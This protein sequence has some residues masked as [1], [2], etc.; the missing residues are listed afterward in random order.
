[1]TSLHTLSNTHRGRKSCKR[2]GRGIGSGLG[3]TCARGQKGAGARSGYKRRLGNEGGQKPLYR[4]LPGR[5]FSNARFQKRFDAV[6]IER[7]N[8]FFE[9][10]EV[11]SME[12]LYEKGLIGSKTYGVKVLSQ[13]DLT[14]KLSFQVHAMSAKSLEKLQAAQS[15]IELL[16]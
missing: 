3:K 14:K 16:Y 2:V 4:K 11:V 13:G 8:E 5:G 6:S 1:M 7:I 12:T 10:G 15:S 9:D